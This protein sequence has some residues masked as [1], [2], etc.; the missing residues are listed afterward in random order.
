MVCET[1]P[2]YIHDAFVVSGG[3]VLAFI[4]MGMA[5]N[6]GVL[7]AELV[8]SFNASR[9]DTS[10]IASLGSGIMYLLGNFL[11]IFFYFIF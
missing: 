8:T 4:S 11:R 7:Y 3:F 10:W 1:G 5:Q 6:F 2:K 9:S